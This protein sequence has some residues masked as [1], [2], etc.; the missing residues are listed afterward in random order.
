LFWAYLAGTALIS[1]SVAIILNIKRQLAATLLGS[2]ILIW[3]IILHTPKVITATS[4]YVQGEIT[5]ALL[6]L[7]YSG[8]AFL[9]AGETK[10]NTHLGE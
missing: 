1:S 8:I 5:S 9:I 2:M 10:L 6:A 3:F 4:I 7:A